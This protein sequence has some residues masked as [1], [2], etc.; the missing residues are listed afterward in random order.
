MEVAAILEGGRCVL[1]RREVA[2]RA[3]LTDT[4]GGLMIY[5]GTDWIQ[6]RS[7]FDNIHELSVQTTS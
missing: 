1:R 3:A 5:V 6:H 2:V 7:R 4:M